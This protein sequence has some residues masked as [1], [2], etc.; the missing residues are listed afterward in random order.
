MRD[1]SRKIS[2]RCSVCGNDQFS[3]IDGDINCLTDA[4]GEIKVRCSDCGAT[5]VKQELIE[6]NR[7]IINANVED[8]RED[9]VKEIQKELKKT[10]GKLR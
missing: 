4:P 8:I 1:L 7:A 10:F 6:N 9:A 2:L 5:Y 3:A